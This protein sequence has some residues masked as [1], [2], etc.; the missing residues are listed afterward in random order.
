MSAGSLASRDAVVDTVDAVLDAD[1]DGTVVGDDL[2]GVVAMLDAEHP[3]RRI[4]TEPSV[5]IAA[6]TQLLDSLVK[7]KVSDATDK[8]LATAVGRRWSYGRDLPD[9]LEYAGVVAHVAQAE[10][11]G[12]LDAVE[13][14]LFRFGRIV[15]GSAELRDVLSNKLAPLAGKQELIAHLVGDKVTETTERLLAQAATGRQRSFAAALDSFQQ[16]AAARRHALI[17]TV[18]VANELSDD[19]R[20]RLAAVLE[21]QYGGSVH[22][23]VIIDPDVLGGARVNIGNEVIDSTVSTRLAEARRMLAG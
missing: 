1:A 5:P 8:V 19:H 15:E 13:D 21:A 3:L 2:F 4:L 7:G 9:G 12:K 22:V 16:V 17:A 18:R 14:E 23:N 11:S 20:Q 6:K 10:S